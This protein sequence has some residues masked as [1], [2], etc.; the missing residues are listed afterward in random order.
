MNDISV[1]KATVKNTDSEF[2]KEHEGLRVHKIDVDWAK[3]AANDVLHRGNK[4]HEDT[5]VSKYFLKKTDSKD[6][7]LGKFFNSM[8]SYNQGIEEIFESLY[9]FDTD[10]EQYGDK[11][12]T[13][14]DFGLLKRELGDAFDISTKIK[15][16]MD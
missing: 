1:S 4:T 10:Q 14:D 8:Q 6:E 15:S 5:E 16:E 13:A 9:A 7:I 11:I 3:T 2:Y 12:F